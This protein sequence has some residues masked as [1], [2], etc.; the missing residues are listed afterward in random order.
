MFPTSPTW[1]IWAQRDAHEGRKEEH[2]SIRDAY[3]LAAAQWIFWDLQMWYPD[4]LYDF[5]TFLSFQRWHF[6]R[7][8]FNA[9]ASGKKEDEKGFGQAAKA[10]EMMD[11]LEKNMTF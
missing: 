4:P 2:G 10:A 11:L 8:N 1:A 5:K 3:V 6:W 7:D 9:V